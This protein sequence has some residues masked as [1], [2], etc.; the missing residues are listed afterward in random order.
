MRILFIDNTAL[1]KSDSSFYT[2]SKNGELMIAL[3]NAG[4][5]VYVFQFVHHSNSISTFDL[6]QHNFRVFPQKSGKN[7]IWSYLIAYFNLFIAVLKCDFV[8]IYYP[9]T[10]KFILPI[11]WLFRKRYAAYVRGMIGANNKL[12]YWIYHHAEFVVQTGRFANEV[13]CRTLLPRPMI[14]YTSKDIFANRVYPTHIDTLKLLYLGRLDREKGLVELFNAIR[15]LKNKEKKVKLMIVGEGRDREM[16]KEEMEKLEIDD[17]VTFYGAEFDPVKI[18]WLYTSADV[19]VIPTYHEGFPRTI[20]ESMIFGTP[21]ITTMVGG[22]PYVMKDKFNCKS[23]DV[24]SADSIV[25]AIEFIID[26]Y[27]NAITWAKN[28]FSTVREILKRDTHADTL[29]KEIEMINKVKK[30]ATKILE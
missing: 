2:Y 25:D 14:N 6:L 24:R 18:R 10:F 26:H 29:V 8:Y 19:Y 3:Q 7:K 30:N 5:D 21:I 22:I 1:I 13:K 9:N 28:G 12:S 16:L 11:C 15:M 23:I 17:K 4:H 20:Y 27:D